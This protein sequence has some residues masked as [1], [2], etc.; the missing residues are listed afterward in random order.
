MYIRFLCVIIMI[1]ALILNSSA[2]ADYKIVTSIS[3]IGSIVAMLVQDKSEVSVI[4]TD[5]ACPHHHHAKPSAFKKIQEADIAIYIDD[6]FDSF[7][8]KLIANSGAKII[9]ISDFERLNLVKFN[10]FYNWHFWLDLDNTLILLEELSKIL[11]IHMPEIS[12]D[13]YSNLNKSKEKIKDLIKIKTELLSKRY[14]VILL[15][16]SLEYFFINNNL[17][18]VKK[19]YEPDY[20]SLKYIDNLERLL[21]EGHNDKCV[22]L[23]PDQSY[24]FY[25][26]FSAP[27]VQLESENWLLFGDLKD[28]FYINYL[29]MIKQI[30]D[31]KR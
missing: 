4:T 29:K 27:V 1:F 23:G 6:Q 25:K 17:Y 18:T 15:S 2:F 12:D 7:A 28:L 22:V 19:L 21:R 30:A 11:I 24:K 31:C 20:K 26:N 9:K 8:A 14:E 5:N 3:P 10:G 13:I 16:D